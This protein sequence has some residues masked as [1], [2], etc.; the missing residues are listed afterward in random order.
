M[1]ASEERTVTVVQKDDDEFRIRDGGVA[2]YGRDDTPALRH[3]IGGVV[4]HGFAPG[5]PLVHMHCWDADRACDVHV[6]GGVDLSG[7]VTLSGDAD[8]PLP[9]Q[10]THRFEGD[11]H[12]TLSIDPIDHALEVSTELARPIHHA[13]QMR[14]PLQLRFC[15]PWHVASDYAVELRVGKR[16][17]LSIRLTGATVATPQACADDS[18]PPVVSHP[19]QP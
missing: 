8:A 17:F 4:M 9:L 2:V 10:M 6:S 3:D 15:N 11:H 7:K 19:F 1:M 5:A 12:Q 16:S 13:L 14:T 18:C